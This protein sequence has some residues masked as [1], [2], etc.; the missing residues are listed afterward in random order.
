M[1][2]EQQKFFEGL[3]FKEC[4]FKYPTGERKCFKGIDGG[5]YRV[6]QFGNTKIKKK[7]QN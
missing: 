4:G 5:Y 7:K 6:D 3:N 2:I 1:V